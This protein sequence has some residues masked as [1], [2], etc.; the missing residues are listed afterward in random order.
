MPSAKS[1]IIINDFNITDLAALLHYLDKNDTAYNEYLQFKEPGGIT[2]KYL[3]NKMKSRDWD[4]KGKGG[5][6]FYSFF[7]GFECFI[8]EKIHEIEKARRKGE[9]FSKVATLDHY[10]CPAPKMFDN[11]GRYSVMD[12][13]FSYYWYEGKYKAKAFRY[14]YDNH[15]NFTYSSIEKLAESYRVKDSIK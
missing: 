13:R 9:T 3:V 10:G 11:M 1:A 14:F 5:K 2:N 6:S 4:R 7:S 8:C 15:L 12:K